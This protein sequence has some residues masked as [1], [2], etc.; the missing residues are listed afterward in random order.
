MTGFIRYDDIIKF[1]ETNTKHFDDSYDKDHAITVYETTL[2]IL[3]NLDTIKT[4]DHDIIMFATL[5]HDLHN[6]KHPNSISLDKLHQFISSYLGKEKTDIVIKIIDNISYSKEIAGNREVLEEPYNTYLIA[7]SDADRIDALGHNGIKRCILYTSI[8]GKIPEDIIKYCYDKLLKLYPHG[9]IKTK[10]A[11]QLAKPLH[12]QVVEYV[13]N[14]YT[15]Q[16]NQNYD[17]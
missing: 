11:R 8:N 2:K 16:I 9:F 17:V 12:D 14:N 1:I 4:H 15:K 6:N 7:I 5:L 10:Y 3:D 13:F